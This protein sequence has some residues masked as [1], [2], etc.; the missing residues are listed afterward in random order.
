MSEGV[1]NL[2]G[3]ELYFLLYLSELMKIR[4]LL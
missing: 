2:S 1:G 4:I 3:I